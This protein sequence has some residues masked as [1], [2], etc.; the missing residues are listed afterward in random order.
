FARSLNLKK[1]DEWLAYTKSGNLPADIPAYPNQTYKDKGW[2]SRGDWLGTGT[3]ANKLKS[4]EY[5]PFKKA[6]TFA[7]SLN[8]KNG[9]EWNAYTKS[10]ELPADIP[11]YP[12]Q[13]Y[14]DNGWA[15]MGDWLGTGR[16][17]S[18]K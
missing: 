9:V 2:I 5:F 3:V 7:R 6:R 16:D 8:L 17:A 4:L 18:Q 12:N 14:K 15:G 11:A 13:T 1:Q 10:G